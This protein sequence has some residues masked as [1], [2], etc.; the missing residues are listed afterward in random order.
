MT[1]DGISGKRQTN[2]LGLA[3]SMRFSYPALI[4]IIQVMFNLSS[5]MGPRVTE[6][7]HETF[8][9]M[10]KRITGLDPNP[11]CFKLNPRLCLSDPNSSD[12]S[13][14]INKYDKGPSSGKPPMGKGRTYE[15]LANTITRKK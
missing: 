8:Q 15:R 4:K 13:S 14:E 2:K 5:A 7:F 1:A 3:G 6:F 10:A 12:N 11:N 9:K